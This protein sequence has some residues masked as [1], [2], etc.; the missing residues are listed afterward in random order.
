MTKKD[1]IK[2]LEYMVNGELG[3]SSKTLISAVLDIPCNHANIPY[4]TSDF[5][6]C[7]KVCFAVPAV[8][9]HLNKVAKRYPKWKPIVRIWG[10]LSEL[11]SKGDYKGVYAELKAVASVPKKDCKR[12]FNG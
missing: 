4:D 8:L 11:Y 7:Y 12:V 5:G 9:K 3:I 1:K 2:L 10:K 6:R